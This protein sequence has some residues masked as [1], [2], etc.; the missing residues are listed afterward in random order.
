MLSVFV[1]V[2]VSFT[3]ASSRV[4]SGIISV[5]SALSVLVFSFE[6]M[7]GRFVFVLFCGLKGG[8]SLVVSLPILST[9]IECFNCSNFL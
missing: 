4:S 1:G 5:V 9:L 2:V 8:S 3:I 7:S 6:L